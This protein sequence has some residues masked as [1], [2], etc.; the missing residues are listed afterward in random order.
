MKLPTGSQI[1][2]A[3]VLA[4]LGQRELA[5]L[6]G[7]NPSTVNRMERSGAATAR[8]QS[9]NVQSVIDALLKQGV[10]ITADGVRVVS[11]TSKR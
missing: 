7:V 4:G 2:A 3:R 10:E 9:R 1:A 6:A 5:A 8:G 11:A